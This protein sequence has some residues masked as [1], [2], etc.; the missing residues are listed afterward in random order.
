MKKRFAKI[1][2]AEGRKEGEGTNQMKGSGTPKK[3]SLAT[4]PGGEKLSG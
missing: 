3:L 2:K 4:S 1:R